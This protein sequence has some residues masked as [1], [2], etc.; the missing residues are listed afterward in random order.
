M[1]L[2]IVTA[3]PAEAEAVQRGLA[4]GGPITVAPVGVGMAVAAA[5]T[6]RL[7]RLAE[8]RYRA[9]ISAGIA[10]GL[11]VPLGGTVLAAHSI[12]ADLGAESAQGFLSLD[13]LG[14]GSATYA[15]DQPLLGS[16][17]Q[18]LAG[19]VVGDVLTVNTVTGTGERLAE[20]V[21]R[22]PAAVAEAMEGYGV[23]SAAALAG[24]PFAELRT[25]SNTV[26]PRDRDSWRI[27][28]AMRALTE[29]AQML[30]TTL[31]S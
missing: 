22:H 21:R 20:L 23:A 12:A 5:T 16:L 18:A 15:V 11:G 25:I 24:V 28:E 27:G 9:V 17:R 8:G 29:A 4:P 7:L 31:S 14:F 3:V 30:S 10:G 26:G 6:A 19:A 13:E 2:L 1:G